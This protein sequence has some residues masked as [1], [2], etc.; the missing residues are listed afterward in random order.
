MVGP[1]A[2][3]GAVGIAQQELVPQGQILVHGELWVALADAPVAAG[4]RV[5]VRGV[6]GLKLL[7]ER[8]RQSVSA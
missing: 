1:E 2:L 3:V 5:R 6:E 4:E 7:V 8:V